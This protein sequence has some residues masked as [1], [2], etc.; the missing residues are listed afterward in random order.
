MI[1]M[2]VLG[3]T[4]DLLGVIQKGTET[5]RPMLN[6]LKT[7]SY[8]KRACRSRARPITTSSSFIL[9]GFGMKS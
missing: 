2:P 7:P 1:C 5:M 4:L 9:K 3:S 6:P 8:L